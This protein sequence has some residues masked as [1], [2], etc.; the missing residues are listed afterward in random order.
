MTTSH[1]EEDFDVCDKSDQYFPHNY[2]NKKHTERVT[3]RQLRLLR[4]VRLE[5][6]TNAVQQLQVTLLGVGIERCNERPRH[7]TRGL[8]GNRGIGTAKMS[9]I[10]PPKKKKVTN[11]V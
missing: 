4:V 7:G 8:R 9:A 6:V 10:S 1:D 5:Q 11:D 2:D 3:A